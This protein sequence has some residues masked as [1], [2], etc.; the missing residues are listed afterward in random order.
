M[1]GE[2]QY[3]I[4]SEGIGC[5]VEGIPGS[6]V[7]IKKYTRFIEHIMTNEAVTFFISRPLYIIIILFSLIYLYLN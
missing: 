2:I 6:Y 5:G 4:T 3:G 7:T 1:C